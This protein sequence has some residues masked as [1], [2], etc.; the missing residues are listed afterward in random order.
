MGSLSVEGE[1]DN[2]RKKEIHVLKLDFNSHDEIQNLNNICMDACGCH[3]TYI[4]TE[5]VPCCFMRVLRKASFVSAT[6]KGFL[7][8]KID[9]IDMTLVCIHDL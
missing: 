8:Y 9:V 4:T 2:F 5:R 1:S 3:S 7:V 6:W